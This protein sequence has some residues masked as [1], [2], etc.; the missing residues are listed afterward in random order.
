MDDFE[1]KSMK[2][3]N[4]VNISQKGIMKI[5]IRDIFLTLTFNILKIYIAL[6]NDLP[7]E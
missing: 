2:H 3:L 7:R 1:K 6:P 4:L 5:V